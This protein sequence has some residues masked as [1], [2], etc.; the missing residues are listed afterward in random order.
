MTVHAEQRVISFDEAVSRLGDAG[1]PFVPTRAARNAA[2]ARDAANAMHPPYVLKAGGLLHKSDQG[3]VVLDLGTPLEVE[4]AARRMLDSIGSTALPLLVQEQQHGVEV[5]VGIQRDRGIGAAVVVGLGGVHT[6]VLA[7]TTLG[8]APL[9]ILRA[10]DMLSRL[11]GW[12]ILAGHRGA[13]RINLDALCDILV[14]ASDLA[15]RSPDIVELDLNPVMVSRQGA[16]AVDVRAVVSPV[17]PSPPQPPGDL[18]RVLRPRHVAVVGVSDDQTKIA[19]RIYSNLLRHGFSG[20]VDAVHPKGGS[21]QNRP[22]YR[23]LDEIDGSPDLVSV[24][25]PAASVLKVAEAAVRARAGALLVHSAGFAESGPEGRRLQQELVDM[26]RRGGVRLI[27]PNSMGIVSPATG[28]VAS[29][30]G[31]L[32]LSS[33]RSGPI[34]ILATSGALSSCIVSRLW[35]AG[36]GISCWVSL[37]NEADVDLAECLESLAEDPDTKTVGLVLEH[38][39]DGARFTVAAQKVLASG[40]SVFA[41]NMGRTARGQAAVATHTGALAGRYALREALLGEAGVVT[42]PRLSILEDALLQAAAGPL[43]SGPRLAVIT[44]SGGASSIMADEAEDAHLLLPAFP[45]HV[46]RALGPLLPGFA[47]LSNPLDVTAQ[48]FGDPASLGSVVEACV[49]PESF[50][51]ILVQFTTNADPNAEITAKAVLGVRERSPIPVFVSRFGADTIAPR[52]LACYREAGVPL[53][54]TPDGAIAVV[55]ALARARA[56]LTAARGGSS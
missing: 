35:E 38:I 26:L 46:A 11:R 50:D 40:K 25:V 7:D 45:A 24:A 21:I 4:E 18:E 15:I 8:I 31:G 27:G 55:A 3:G 34:A 23:S 28:L 51:A 16:I 41:C 37:G 20:R 5:L 47:T 17:P 54:D 48:L 29:F 19:G 56:T 1:I 42:V 6:E 14:Q 52:G 30:A 9:T 10:H 53:M 33:L 22:R 2:D 39:S 32:E 13:A 43:P 49:D 36:A 44:G 12:P